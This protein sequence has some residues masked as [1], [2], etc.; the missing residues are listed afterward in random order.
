MSVDFSDLEN[1]PAALRERAQWLLWRFEE[2]PG[3][4]KPRKVPYYANGHRRTGKQGDDRDRAQLVS[5][6]QVR[7][8]LV[9][10]DWSGVGFAFL[11]GDGL[12]GIDLD[13]VIDPE[14]GAV[15]E[16]AAGIVKACASFTEYSP[17]GK[18]LHIYVLG[19][20]KS[21]KSNEI[22][23]EV[24]C[25]RQFFTVTGR[26]FGDTPDEATPI[27]PGVLERLHQRIN[28][29]KAGGKAARAGVASTGSAPAPMPPVG[30]GEYAERSRIESALATISADVG[31]NDWIAIG[32][33]LYDALGEQTGL[34]VWDY[35]SSRGAKY[36]GSDVLNGHWRSFGNR[37]R[38]GDGV[39]FRLAMEHGWRPP[40]KQRPAPMRAQTAPAEPPAVAAEQKHFYP[41]P[42]GAG[43][44]PAGPPPGGDDPTEK[45]WVKRLFYGYR[46]GVP[47][48]KD[49]R[50]NVYLFLAFHPA[51]EGMLKADTF[52][53]KIVMMRRPPWH[54]GPFEPGAEWKEDH[55]Y[56]LGMWLGEHQGLLVRSVDTLALAAGWAAREAPFNPVQEYV[57]GVVW[58]RIERLPSFTTDY[59]GVKPS[60]YASRSGVY[61]WLSLIARIMEPGA[62]VR[63]MPILEGPQFQGKSTVVR[64]IGGR[65]YSDTPLDLNSK[66]VYQNIQGVLIYE[67]AELDAFNK[68]EST[69]IK[70][71]ISS[72]KD[73]FR[74]PY[75]R[76]PA[77]HWRQTV[78]VGTTNQDEYFKDSTGN[79]RYWPWRTQV[80]GSIE[81][82]ALVRDRDQLFAEAYYRYMQG[83]RW[84]PTREEQERLFE[85]EQ[86]ERE[87]DDPWQS[88][89]ERWLRRETRERVTTVDVITE[90]L[91]IEVGK[92]DNTRQM[93]TRIGIT[94]KRLGWI[95]RRESTGARERYYERPE[96]WKPGAKP[97]SAA[98]DPWEA[99]DVAY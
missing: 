28:E 44:E 68:A 41:A 43:H 98:R 37:P 60:E 27:T 95:N 77:D 84:H 22:G 24:F 1:V 79:T 87:I 18:G 53:R 30:S 93:S 12:I 88:I 76:E 74:A 99:N 65:W 81:L 32:M 66:D 23:L 39:I 96:S 36:G 80:V 61:F 35:W 71:F 34:A 19:E 55:N 94:M 75:D 5:F 31:Y 90:C 72:L 78:F 26:R 52:A 57:Q 45:D 85:P 48:L 46:N 40:A 54:K 49:C 58:D 25:G 56:R 9:V 14:T 69:R 86:S 13:G 50:E 64:I 47:F 73:R 59:L 67:I 89:I 62:V 7:A 92:I 2:K 20:T 4:K 82:D 97:I 51:L 29:A 70:A 6:D 17:S 15:Q 16:R 91:K 21:N 42:A 3:D 33:A 38:G 10:G 8:E 83:E 11:P 63:S